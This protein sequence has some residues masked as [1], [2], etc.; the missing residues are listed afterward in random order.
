MKKYSEIKKQSLKEDSH[1][2]K[3]ALE[4]YINKLKLESDEKFKKHYPATWDRG[5]QDFF[6]YKEGGKFYKIVVGSGE[7]V[8]KTKSGSVF[9]F[10]DKN[11]GD[12]YK[13]ASWNAPAKGVRGNI[14]E[15]DL[16][17]T[18]QSLYRR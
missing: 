7:A 18:G 1:D 17:L 16:P 2:V 4:D 6:T 3:K 12:I 15:K 5:G 13:A 11:N 10:V 14:F 8:L 9:A